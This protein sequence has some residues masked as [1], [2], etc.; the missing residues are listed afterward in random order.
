MAAASKLALDFLLRRAT[1]TLR[2]LPVPNF[3]QD[4][5][6]PHGCGYTVAAREGSL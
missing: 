1:M 2:Q 6:N 3:I 5:E 4:G